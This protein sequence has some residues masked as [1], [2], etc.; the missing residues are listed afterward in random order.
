MN[1][2]E[3]ISLAIEYIE[4]HLL[5]D[6]TIYDIA[7]HVGL[8]PFYFQKGFSMI[9]GLSMSEYTRKR[10][11]SLAGD[12]LIMGNGKVIDIAL[13]YGYDSP[14]SFTKAF[15]RFHGVTPRSVKKGTVLKTFAPLQ[16]N[17]ILKGGYSMNYK[18]VEKG[19]FTVLGN[20]RKLSYDNPQKEIPEFWKEHFSLG[21]GKYVHGVFGINIDESMAQE[22]FEYVIADL[23]DPTID[24]PKDFVLRTIPALTW[25]VFPCV[26]PVIETLQD[27]NKK[28]FT[29]WLP[30]LKD[31]E[32]AC[33]YCIEMYDDP[34]H[35][36]LKTMDENYYCEIWIPIRKKNI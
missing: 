35:Y 12:D 1:W 19:S 7:Q 30:S 27:I 22:E 34:L 10:R 36:P 23:Y 31:Y 18:I 25:A 11:L 8:S 28:I 26:G 21:K 16:I 9:C 2:V 14:D 20:A 32:L 13:K 29:Q 17:I 15:T 4:N 6:I 5:E 3:Y 33:G 24:I